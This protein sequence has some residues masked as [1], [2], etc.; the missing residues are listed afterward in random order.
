MRLWAYLLVLS[1]LWGASFPL[2]RFA[3]QTMPPLALSS[4]RAGI[5]AVALGLFLCLTRQAVRA[6]G[7]MLRHMLVLGT[8]NGWLPN[9]L[10]AMA[11]GRVTSAQA[12][13][14]GACGPLMVAV[15]AASVLREDAMT[16][17]RVAGTL[18]G[19]GGVAAIMAPLAVTGGGSI[20]GGLL[21]LGTALCY[22]VGT[23]YARLTQPGSSAG[24]VLGQQV[25]AFLPALA[26]AL[27]VH[28]AA[29]F[30]Q[31]APVWAVTAILGVFASAV[32]MVLF[33]RMLQTTQ[34][35]DAALVGYLQPVWATA[36]AAWLLAEWP[37]P[38]VLAG[39]AVVLAGVWL[40]SDRRP[41]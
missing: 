30:M 29:S 38:R 32:P 10:L 9:M 18:L 28:P 24:L 15:L 11:L 33:L 41:A 1:G 12:A 16:P 21:M 34:A 2:V 23:V 17:R 22:A 26:L 20:W 37:E 25:F 27:I 35:A 6:D 39:G 4:A 3:V 40:A 8:I 19:F 31:P 36:I 7:A 13:L 14:I 5:A